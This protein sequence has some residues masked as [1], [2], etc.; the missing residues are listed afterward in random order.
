MN[1]RIA[2][3]AISVLAVGVI[4]A[5]YFLWQ[6]TTKLGEAE[7]EIVTLEGDVSTLKGDVSTLE[8]DVS[9][10]EGTVSTL[11]GDVSTL[12]GNVSTLEGDVSTL[13]GDVSTLES[14]L[15]DS[16]ATVSTLEA[17]L[18]TA[19]AEKRRLQAD[20]ST[21]QTIN[22]TLSA[23]LKK[24][25]DPRHFASTQ[26]LADWLQEDDTD[27]RYADEDVATH[28]FILQIRAL[29]DGYLLPALI[30]ETAGGEILFGSWVAIGDELY[31]V[32]A[33]DDN[34]WYVGYLF[35]P[36]GS[37]PLPLD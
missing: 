36:Q 28:C 34:V 8:G 18:E 26:E 1:K 7:S 10:L 29:R 21:Q 24:V 12:E 3:P 23:E 31:G 17:D 22:S 37:H 14:E 15:A 27:T 4:V 25:K 5:G 6:Q 9:T 32:T 33:W 2:I 30:I 20:V 16:E 35:Q 11:E 13:E 19:N